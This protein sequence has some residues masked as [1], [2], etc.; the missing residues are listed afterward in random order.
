MAN[1]F[2]ELKLVPR[3][4]EQLTY[5]LRVTIERIR[6]LERYIMK[7]CVNEAH[8]PRRDFIQT[9]P[10][11]ETNLDWLDKHVKNGKP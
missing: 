7:L 10:D 3:L 5:D 11:N 6:G 2:M 9:F 4:V 1:Y 8:M